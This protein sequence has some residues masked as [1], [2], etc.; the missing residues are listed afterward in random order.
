MSYV[1]LKLSVLFHVVIFSFN[2]LLPWCTQFTFPKTTFFSGLNFLSVL[3]LVFAVMFRVN[4]LY[5]FKPFFIQFF[6]FLIINVFFKLISSLLDPCFLSIFFFFMETRFISFNCFFIGAMI[7]SH[8]LLSSWNHVSF[9]LSFFMVELCFLLCFIH[10][11]LFNF[12]W[13]LSC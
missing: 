4:W 5:F 12:H 13:L 8:F 6:V 10:G 7:L 2:L 3:S 11:A 9:Q 1:F